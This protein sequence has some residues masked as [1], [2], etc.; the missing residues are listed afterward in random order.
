[1]AGGGG[2]GSAALVSGCSIDGAWV[3]AASSAGSGCV[4]DAFFDGTGAGL[5]A[6]MLAQLFFGPPSGIRLLFI[7]SDAAAGVASE[8]TTS[9]QAL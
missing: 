9:L 2:T 6:N 4:P 5:A 1:M 3:A 7:P 8:V